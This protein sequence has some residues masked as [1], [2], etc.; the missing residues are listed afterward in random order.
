MDRR[1]HMEYE[2]LTRNYLKKG[3]KIRMMNGEIFTVKF[4]DFT[5]VYV[6]ESVSPVLKKDIQSVLSETT[7]P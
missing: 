5:E 6:N 7:T 4:L 1:E 3:D 2:V